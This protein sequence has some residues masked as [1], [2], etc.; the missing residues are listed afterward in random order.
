VFDD[1][2]GMGDCAMSESSPVVLHRP[3]R[4]GKVR[5]YHVYT[6]GRVSSIATWPS[7]VVSERDLTCPSDLKKEL[8]KEARKG[9]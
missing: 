3:D 2:K 6:S 9:K 5:T 8:I 4:K 1:G 7:G